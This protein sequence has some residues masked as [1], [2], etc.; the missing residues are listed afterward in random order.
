MEVWDKSK[1]FLDRADPSNIKTTPGRLCS[2]LVFVLIPI[3]ISLSR[4]T[5]IQRESENVPA[6]TTLQRRSPEFPPRSAISCLRHLPFA[7]CHFAIC[8]YPAGPVFGVR[9][10]NIYQTDRLMLF[11]NPKRERQEKTALSAIDPSIQ[12]KGFDLGK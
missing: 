5:K 9:I 3:D 12:L 11:L 1:L 10:T 7:N 6:F 4:G 8:R 2:P